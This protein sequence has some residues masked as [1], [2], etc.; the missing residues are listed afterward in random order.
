MEENEKAYDYVGL[1]CGLGG[2]SQVRWT[3]VSI[4]GGSQLLPRARAIHQDGVS[5]KRGVK[6]GSQDCSAQEQGRSLQAMLEET[7]RRCDTEG[8]MSLI[9]SLESNEGGGQPT[10]AGLVGRV[11]AK[12]ALILN[13]RTHTA[14]LLYLTTL[15]CTGNVWKE[16][17]SKCA[18]SPKIFVRVLVRI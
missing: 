7:S 5:R 3:K 18:R 13:V 9:V 16:V 2:G 8:G 14:H 4:H 11:L 15:H 12:A 1:F 17:P 10:R 6:G